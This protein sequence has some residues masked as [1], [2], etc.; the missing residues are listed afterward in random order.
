MSVITKPSSHEPNDLYAKVAGLISSARQQVR[1]AVNQAMVMTYWQIGQLI[2]EDE[3][4]G[5]ARAEYGKTVLKKMS[6]RLTQQFGKGFD[7]SNLRYMRRFYLAFPI[8]DALRPDL[9]W[10]H[11]RLLLRVESEVARQ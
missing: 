10:T 1:S 5:K 9:S 3:Q 6:D 8:R 7:I 4:S 11:Y 2:V